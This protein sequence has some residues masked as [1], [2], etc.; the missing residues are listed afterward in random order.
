MRESAWPAFALQIGDRRWEIGDRRYSPGSAGILPAADGSWSLP[1]PPGSAGILPATRPHQRPPWERGHL[2]RGPFILSFSFLSLMLN[3]R[4]CH[5]PAPHPHSNS[6]SPLQLP[7]GEGATAPG[8]GNRRGN[9]RCASCAVLSRR[10][11]TSFRP[12]PHGRARPSAS[13]GGLG[14]LLRSMGKLGSGS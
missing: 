9:A 10:P 8:L 14:R 3:W 2:A 1:R 13:P 4:F 11:E 5:F 6:N 12:P 7:R